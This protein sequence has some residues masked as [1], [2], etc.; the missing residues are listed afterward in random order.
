MNIINL[1]TPYTKQY[2]DYSSLN[3]AINFKDYI[4]CFDDMERLSDK[5]D[6]KDILGVVD[7]LLSLQNAKVIVLAN[8]D[9]LLNKPKAEELETKLNDETFE[10]R[11]KAY[12]AYKKY[13]I[14]NIY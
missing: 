1:S 10:K 14:A 4:F 11:K 5:A 7:N 2:I 3:T 9:E 13:F 8:E 6:I 12:Q